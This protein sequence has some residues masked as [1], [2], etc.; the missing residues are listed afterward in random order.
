ML[1][2]L[3]KLIN[4]QAGFLDVVV[5]AISLVI[6]IFSIFPFHNFIQSKVAE[7]LGDRTSKNQGMQTLN[8]FAH[9][10]YAGALAMIVFGIGWGRH[11]YINARNFKN[12]KRDIAIVA[13][14]GLL[15]NLLYA[16]VLMLISNII[17]VVSYLVFDGSVVLSTI[18]L[19]LTIAA[20]VAISLTVF[21]LLPIP[22]LDGAKILA[23]VLPDRY[24]YRYLS[25]ERY[26]SLILILLIA[27]NVLDYPLAYAGSYIYQ[28]LSRVAW[29]P[30]FWL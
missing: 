29:L 1:E 27:T 16:L 15:A 6:L 12:P 28:L 22:P 19:I 30:F 13:A 23:S 2:V 7:K 20:Q 21:Y 14:T 26:F 9:I 17:T 24:Y 8:P 10:D 5:R 18:C 4:G 3:I 25:F 11:S